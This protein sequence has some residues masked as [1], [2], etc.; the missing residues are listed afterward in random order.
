[1]T[2]DESTI[3]EKGPRRAAR[4]T[5]RTHAV[6]QGLGLREPQ[7]VRESVE[8]QDD[9]LV[10]LL[11][12]A[13]K[14]RGRN[15]PLAKHIREGKRIKRE[16]LKIAATRAS[17][18]HPCRSAQGVQAQIHAPYVDRGTAEGKGQRGRKG[19]GHPF[20]LQRAREA[21]ARMTDHFLGRPV[22]NER[23]VRRISISAER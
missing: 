13:M 9:R 6:R 17:G 7:A 4:A 3:V 2:H 14:L 16:I 22:K 10:D 1:M 19:C 11:K 20:P 15:L 18:R 12:Q 23:R 21:Q 5:R 8:M